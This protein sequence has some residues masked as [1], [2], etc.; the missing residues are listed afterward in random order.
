[1]VSTF[2]EESLHHDYVTPLVDLKALLLEELGEKMPNNDQFTASSYTA[3]S[4]AYNAIVS[5]INAEGADLESINVSE[6]KASAEDKLVSV[7][8]VK[9]NL[10]A[11]LG[12]KMANNNYQYT[13]ESYA[14]YLSAYEAI[15]A[16]INSA[17]ADIESINVTELKISAEAKLEDMPISDE[18]DANIG[19]TDSSAVIDVIINYLGDSPDNI[20]YSVDVV[21]NDITFT[22]DAGN[23]QWDPEKHDFG[24]TE[25]SAGWVDSSGYITVI[26]HSNAEVAIDIT[27]EQS[28]TPNGTADLTVATPSFTL[29]NSI[30]TLYNEAP[31][32]TTEITVGG[33]PQGG[34]SIGK[35]TVTISKVTES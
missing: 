6:L 19:D 26:N 22:Y 28:E 10:L 24:N 25:N 18:G 3:Y 20:V 1:V 9:A 15:V 27:F 35:L 23:A 2:S 8:L 29:G 12:E 30:G 33:V 13:E 14:E 31:K 34:G 32:Q 11:E 4:N 21:W 7:D 5:Q 17:G 16:Q